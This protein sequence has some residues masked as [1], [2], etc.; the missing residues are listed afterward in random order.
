MH[1]IEGGAGKEGFTAAERPACGR[2]R[3]APALDGLW[4][5]Y[6]HHG[7][8]TGQYSGSLPPRHAGS[9]ILFA[10]RHSGRLIAPGPG[11]PFHWDG[12]LETL[13]AGIDASASGCPRQ[14]SSAPRRIR[15]AAAASPPVSA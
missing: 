3:A 12:T 4:P 6:N 10:D 9:Q 15:A 14:V 2:W 1:V 5:E 7:N 13:P 11:H 8:Q